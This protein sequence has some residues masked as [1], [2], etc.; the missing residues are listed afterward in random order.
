MSYC[1]GTSL[2]VLPG[3]QAGKAQVFGL[4][5]KRRIARVLGLG[6]GGT[7]T[8]PIEAMPAPFF[9]GRDIARGR[10]HH[11]PAGGHLRLDLADDSPGRVGR[12]TRHSAN[13]ASRRQGLRLVQPSPW[14]SC[15][16][17]SS[18]PRRCRG[19]KADLQSQRPL[20]RRYVRFSPK[21]GRIDIV[22][23]ESARDP[24]RT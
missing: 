10:A 22:T 18:A 4:I 1:R 5:I 6:P 21:S 7:V 8:S 17:V 19:R 12:L 23:M 20:F 3:F 13:Q 2:H 15:P 24:K 11:H 16:F 14:V 9:M